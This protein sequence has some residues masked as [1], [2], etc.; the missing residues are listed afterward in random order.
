MKSEIEQRLNTKRELKKELEVV[1]C[2]FSPKFFT[3]SVVSKF[4]PRGINPDN[5]ANSP[6]LRKKIAKL[7]GK[8]TGN[9]K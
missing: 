6:H 3:K 5:M 1:G 9:L 7:L 2:T 4:S 8:P